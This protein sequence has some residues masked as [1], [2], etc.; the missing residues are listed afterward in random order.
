MVI[1]N[2]TLTTGLAAK[3]LKAKAKISH[4][5]TTKMQNHRISVSALGAHVV[6]IGLAKQEANSRGLTTDARAI[7]K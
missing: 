7:E 4:V 1:L 6:V 3:A 2:P 5:A